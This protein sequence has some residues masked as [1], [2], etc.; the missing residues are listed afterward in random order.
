[1]PTTNHLSLVVPRLFTI[2]WLYA[3]HYKPNIW[4]LPDILRIHFPNFNI[5]QEDEEEM[6]SQLY[7]GNHQELPLSHTV[8][9]AWDRISCV[10]R[11]LMLFCWASRREGQEGCNY[12]AHSK[13]PAV[14]A[15]IF[16]ARDLASYRLSPAI[17]NRANV[18][19]DT[20][21]NLFP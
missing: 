19:V 12:I 16:L 6:T 13:T 1:M 21:K 2:W 18:V 11:D 8:S 9:Q 5:L 10:D 20:Y 4:P 14:D 17:R 7:N 15:K 3:N